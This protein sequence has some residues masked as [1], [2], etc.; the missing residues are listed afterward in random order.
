M[1]ESKSDLRRQLIRERARSA[2]LEVQATTDVLTGL[3]NRRYAMMT[4]TRLASKDRRDVTSG[5]S[6]RR[7]DTRGYA[8][9]LLDIDRFK[10]VNDTY[11]HPAGDVVLIGVARG[12]TKICRATDIL[13]RWGGE[14]FLVICPATT[15]EEALALAHRLRLCVE[16]ADAEQSVLSWR[17][18][19]SVGVSQ[20]SSFDESYADVIRRA[21]AALYRAKNQGRNR[22]VQLLVENAA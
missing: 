19:A 10:R 18:T 1:T 17:L 2:A 8:L 22:V 13:T 20:P 4:L 5:R 6:D 9:L 7:K 3:H 12:M 11:G 14:E 21:D 16:R 15:P